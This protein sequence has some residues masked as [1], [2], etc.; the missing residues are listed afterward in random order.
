VLLTIA[1][2]AGCVLA[3]RRSG[4]LKVGA[5]LVVGR[6]RVEVVAGLVD[7]G[8]G[9]AGGKVVGRSALHHAREVGALAVRP[10]K[11]LETSQSVKESAVNCLTLSS[12]SPGDE[13]VRAATR[14]QQSAH[15]FWGCTG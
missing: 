2:V 4:A 9:D 6:A 1:V 10:A 13:R 8:G 15:P 3:Q 14:Q 11:V 5:A 12:Q 7:E